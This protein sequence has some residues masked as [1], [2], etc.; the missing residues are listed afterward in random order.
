[1]IACTVTKRKKKRKDSICLVFTG[2]GGKVG[3]SPG[4]SQGSPKDEKTSCRPAGVERHMRHRK[5]R[6]QQKRGEL[7]PIV[8]WIPV[9]KADR[10]DHDDNERERGLKVEPFHGR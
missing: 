7:R 1:M 3:G 9:E 4:L 5:T 6:N 8:V 10:S 2:S